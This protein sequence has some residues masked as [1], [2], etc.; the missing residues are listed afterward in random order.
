VAKHYTPKHSAKGSAPKRGH[1]D[2]LQPLDTGIIE[3]HIRADAGAAQYSEAAAQY[4]GPAHYDGQARRDEPADAFDP[5]A[6]RDGQLAQGSAAATPS[7][8][9]NEADLA[10]YRRDS[11]SY[12][13]RSHRGRNIAIAVIAAVV[14]IFGGL[15]GAA[16]AFWNNTQNAI[17]IKDTG[18]KEEL[19]QEVSV[20]EPFWTLILGSD[21]REGPSDV[22]GQRSDVILLARIDPASKHVTFV[23]IPRDSLVYINGHQQK[24]NAAYSLGGAKQA[25]QTIEEYAG[26]DIS[27]Y[28]EVNFS[29]FEQLVDQLGGITVDV[30]EYASYGGISLNPGVQD[31]NGEQAL[32]LARN[33]KTYSDGDFTRTT[34]QRLIAQ[35][36]VEKV[37]QKDPA[38]LATLVPSIAQCFKTDMSLTDIV[39]LANAMQGMSGE[40]ISMAMAPS[41]TGMIGDASYTFTYINQWKLLMQRASNGEDPTITDKEAAILGTTSTQTEKLDMS[42][43]IPSTVLKKLQ[44]LENSEK[45]QELSQQKQ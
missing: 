1:E 18:I 45:Q 30:P 42:Q 10:R 11:A 44:E 32:M 38:E 2:N 37:L 12:K 20:S 8:Q 27:H 24:I 26:I 25:I 5:F 15:G 23:S 6:P 40:N 43:P 17:S 33:R 28:I 9:A 7:G 3:T 41:T 14:L 31:L 39:A 22:S 34:C 19:Q 16:F 35:A 4:E 36:I 13:K 21:E 29:G